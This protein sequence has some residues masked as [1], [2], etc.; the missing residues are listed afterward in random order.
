MTDRRRKIG[1][2]VALGA[3]IRK[4]REELD[5]TLTDMAERV[6]ISKGHLSEV[7]HGMNGLSLWSAAAIAESL[8]WGLDEMTKDVL[9]R[10]EDG[11]PHGRSWRKR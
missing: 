4:R 3:R 8:G 1:F 9:W 2:N 7:E 5:V 6:G 10:E 11:A